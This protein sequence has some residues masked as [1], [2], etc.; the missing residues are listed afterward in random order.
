M[1]SDFHA[2]DHLIGQLVDTDPTET[3]EWSESLDAVIKNAGPVRARYLMLS[4]MEKARNNNLGV[5]A[6]RGTDYINTISPELEP[7]FPG[8]ERNRELLLC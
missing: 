5:S 8:D 7:D 6:L 3:A 2:P 1:S 4:L